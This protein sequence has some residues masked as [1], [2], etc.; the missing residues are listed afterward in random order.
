MT[1]SG[2]RYEVGREHTKAWLQYERLDGNEY[3]SQW[4]KKTIHTMACQA[5]SRVRRPP[6]SSSRN[7]L[8][9]LRWGVIK[10]CITVAVKVRA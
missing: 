6:P 8:K 4:E 1:V 2:T 9:A 10:V 7:V 5:N 3:W